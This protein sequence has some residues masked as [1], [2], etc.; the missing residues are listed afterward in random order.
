MSDY[1]LDAIDIEQKLRK[2]I[3]RFIALYNFMTKSCF[4]N[5]SL[6]DFTLPFN[7][8]DYFFDAIDVE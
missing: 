5:L 1:F 2:W 6:K 4:G 3:I 8:S 7:V